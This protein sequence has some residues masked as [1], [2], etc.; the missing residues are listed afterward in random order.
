MT[1]SNNK[2][3][4]TAGPNNDEWLTPRYITDALGPFDVDPCSP[5]V[6]PW[7]TARTHLNVND[8]GLTHPWSGFVWANPPY[9]KFTFNFLRRLASHPDGGIG[10][11]FARTETKGFH[12]EVWDK[13]DAVFFFASRLKFCYVDGTDGNTA[14]AP[15]VLVAYGQLAIDRILAAQANG[16][17][18]GKFIRLK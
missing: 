2:S 1:T 7:D 12:S 9:G 18:K 5:I 10:L 13:A 16:S 17:I 3:F 14:N 8:D 11:I 4:N 15:S 6:R